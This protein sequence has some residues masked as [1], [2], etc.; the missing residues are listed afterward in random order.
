M[1]EAGTRHKHRV[2]VV[3]A[4][5]SRNRRFR[6]AGAEGS[7]SRRFRAVGAAGTRRKRRRSGDEVAVCTACRPLA[8]QCSRRGGPKAQKSLA[9]SLRVLQQKNPIFLLRVLSASCLQ[10]QSWICTF[11]YPSVQSW[12]K[13]FWR[14]HSFNE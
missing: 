9:E 1:G 12:G 13:C 6:A 2:R 5:G 8:F 7:R 4:E 10:Q 11:E 14:A 3:G